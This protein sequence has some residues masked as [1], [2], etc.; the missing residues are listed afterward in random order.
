MKNPTSFSALGKV[1]PV[2]DEMPPSSVGDKVLKPPCKRC[3]KESLFQC[4]KCS[5]ERYCSQACQSLDWY[6]H[7]AHCLKDLS[8]TVVQNGCQAEVDEISK[9]RFEEP[10]SSLK[11]ESKKCT[12]FEKDL[13]P[14]KVV[15]VKVCELL[16][17]FG[18]WALIKPINMALD[19]DA[20]IMEE[21]LED[22]VLQNLH[23]PPK[24][25]QLALTKHQK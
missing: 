9:N 25:G 20:A 24:E 21:L 3:G 2:N 22:E 11:D 15:D 1:P 10:Q 5:K 8:I 19:V 17:V 7:K 16:D 13:A 14:C 12:Y 23:D 18:K 4:G 6:S